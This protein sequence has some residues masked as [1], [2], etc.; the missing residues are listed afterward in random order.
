MAK[1]PAVSAKSL[2]RRSAGEAPGG[3]ES[4]SGSRLSEAVLNSIFDTAAPDAAA[5][6]LM[7]VLQRLETVSQREE[8]DRIQEMV[9]SVQSEF[10]RVV[11]FRDE[12]IDKG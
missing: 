2:R 3:A 9:S 1:A 8:W 11:E 5:R 7:D 4:D 6:P 10:E 12:R